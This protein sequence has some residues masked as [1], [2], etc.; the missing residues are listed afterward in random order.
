MSEKRSLQEETLITTPDLDLAACLS[1]L[2]VPFY[3]RKPFVK[4]KN[5][6][7]VEITHFNFQPKSDDG[8]F[9]AEHLVRCWNDSKFADAN[10]EHPLIYAK[11]ALANRKR[12]VDTIK[13]AAPLISIKKHIGGKT[14]TY[15]VREGGETHKKLTEAAR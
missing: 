13:S 14:Y 5:T 1:A 9:D 3:D 10:K 11:F 4:I 6:A 12:I 2:G 8:Q 7:G 15:L